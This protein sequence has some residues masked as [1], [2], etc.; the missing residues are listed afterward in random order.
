M[1]EHNERIADSKINS[2]ITHMPPGMVISKPT[3]RLIAAAIHR[4]VDSELKRFAET[5]IIER[6]QVARLELFY[7]VRDEPEFERWADALRAFITADEQQD[8]KVQS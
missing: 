7:T 5:G 3:A 6:P 8:K 4:G 1:T 2:E